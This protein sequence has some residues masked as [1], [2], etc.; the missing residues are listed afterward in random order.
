MKAAGEWAILSSYFPFNA[1]TRSWNKEFVLPLFS[2]QAKHVVHNLFQAIS[3]FSSLEPH[4]KLAQWNLSQPRHNFVTYFL[5]WQCMSCCIICVGWVWEEKAN[6]ISWRMHLFAYE[7]NEAF[8]NGFL[9]QC[10]QHTHQPILLIALQ[11]LNT[12]ARRLCSTCML[13]WTQR[14]PLG[15]KYC[16]LRQ[17]GL[18]T[19]VVNLAVRSL[20]F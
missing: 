7:R 8:R 9:T 2:E 17:G 6:T 18:H 20:L 15:S 12:R 14:S 11:S 4:R 13:R 10:Q 3:W 1:I 5:C 19:G 16:C